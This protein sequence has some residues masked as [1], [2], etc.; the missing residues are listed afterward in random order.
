M[1]AFMPKIVTYYT[2]DSMK[3]IIILPQ[4]LL[5]KGM[6]VL[7]EMHPLRWV[8]RRCRNEKMEYRSKVVMGG[9]QRKEKLNKIISC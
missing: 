9:T 1:Y 6:L 2:I 8:Q 5:T 7:R 4:I 3:K